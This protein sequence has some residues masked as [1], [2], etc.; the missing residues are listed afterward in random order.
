V[1]IKSG[2]EGTVIKDPDMIW[3]DGTNKYQVKI[4]VEFNCD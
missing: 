4:K 2:K 1:L 3:E